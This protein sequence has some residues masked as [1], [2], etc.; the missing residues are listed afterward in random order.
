MSV[1]SLAIITLCVPMVLLSGT[2]QDEVTLL[3]WAG[4]P[5]SKPGTFKEWIISHSYTNFSVKLGRT[6]IRNRKG[7][8]VAILIGST[9]ASSVTDEINQLMTN[10]QEEGYT[11][12]SY[13]VSGGT[14]ESLRSFL[15]G[16]YNT[17]NIE[18]ALF[19]G[20]LPV[21]WFQVK[22]DF[23]EYGYAEWPIDL[24]YMDLDGN[25]FDTLKYHLVD[26]LVP[27][28]DSIYDAH[29]GNLSPEIYIGRLTPTGIGDDTLLIK[30][31]LSKII[32]L[33]IKYYIFPRIK[34]I[35]HKIF[36]KKFRDRVRI[37]ILKT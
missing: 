37:Y 23:N 3:R 27:G 22:N 4:P 14:P 24:F 35:T 19:I 30:N 28:Q 15:Q 5:G 26:T 11:V 25:W 13:E 20:D 34:G 33:F 36:S 7:S 21:A 12:S 29:S 2:P 18:G 10:L 32:L 1:R 31:Y 16:L 6:V 17:N 9:V 8:T